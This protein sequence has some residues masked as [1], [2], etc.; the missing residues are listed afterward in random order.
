MKKE[1]LEQLPEGRLVKKRE[2]YYHV[3]GKK[4]I[5]ITNN[6]EL[7]RQLARKKFLLEQKKDISKTPKDIIKSLPNSYQNLPQS[8]FYHTDFHKWNNQPEVK[9]SYPMATTYHSKNGTIVRSKSEL[10]IA[11]ALE[12]YELPYRYD[13]LLQLV[14]QKMYPD[15]IIKNPFTNKTIIWEHFGALNQPDYEQRM[16]TKMKIYL[17]QGF[18]PFHNLIYTSEFDLNRIN[19]IIEKIIL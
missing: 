15:F 11:N 18:V 7:I 1:E 5:G 14:E 4:E 19:D 2:F 12:E 17:E 6:T 8:F 13:N 9:N 16:T 3:I 10:I